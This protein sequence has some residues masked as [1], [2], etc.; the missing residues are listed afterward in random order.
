MN[1]ERVCQVPGVQVVEVLREFI[2]RCVCWKHCAGGHETDPVPGKYRE[3]V[4]WVAG[5]QNIDKSTRSIRVLGR[6]KW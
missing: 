2:R 3:K 4:T 6:S 1:E 5:L